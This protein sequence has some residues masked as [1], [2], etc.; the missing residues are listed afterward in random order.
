VPVQN[1]QIKNGAYVK[2]GVMYMDIDQIKS[3]FKSVAYTDKGTC[4]AGTSLPL[5]DELN[6]T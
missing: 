4:A 2:D 5:K 3:D 1:A 6:D